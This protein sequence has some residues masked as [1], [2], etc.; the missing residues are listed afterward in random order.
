VRA[1]VTAGIAIAVLATGETFAATGCGGSTTSTSSTPTLTSSPGASIE[2]VVDEHP[3]VV[4][5]VCNGIGN[6]GRSVDVKALGY[7]GPLAIDAHV[8]PPKLLDE[9]VSRC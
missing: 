6:G 7:V 5:I 2:Q 8:P 1:R 4:E 3:D 9:F